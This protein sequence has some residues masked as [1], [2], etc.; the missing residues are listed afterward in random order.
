MVTVTPHLWMHFVALL[1]GINPR[2]A[3]FRLKITLHCRQL[4]GRLFTFQSPI[5]IARDVSD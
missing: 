4:R 3:S 2:T 1:A 5:A